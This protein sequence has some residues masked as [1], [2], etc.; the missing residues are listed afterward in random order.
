[1]GGFGGEAELVED[2]RAAGA[3]TGD[4]LLDEQRADDDVVED[5]QAGERLDQLEG[6]AD[7]GGGRSKSAPRFLPG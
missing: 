1:V 2:A 5:G 6:A 4:G 7:A 3:R